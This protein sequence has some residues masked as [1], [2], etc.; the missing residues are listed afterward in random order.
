MSDTQLGPGTMQVL[1]MLSSFQDGGS[2]LWGSSLPEGG[3]GGAAG[4]DSLQTL[5]LQ[6]MMGKRNKGLV[7]FCW[8][9]AD[10]EARLAP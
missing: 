5:P 2:F 10:P 7:F 3:G 1:C 8:R 9:T 6:N 4:Q